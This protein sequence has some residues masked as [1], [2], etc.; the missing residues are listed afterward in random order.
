MR[1]WYTKR[2][3][4]PA[5]SLVVHLRTEHEDASPQVLPPAELEAIVDA[6]IAAFDRY[7]Q[8]E[9]GNKPMSPAERAIVKTYLY[10]KTMV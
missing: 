1:A 10:Y 2:M 9:L 5:S 8:G 4:T 3:P 6:D 7:F